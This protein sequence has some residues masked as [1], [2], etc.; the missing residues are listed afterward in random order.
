MNMLLAALLI[1][2]LSGCRR[3]VSG[4]SGLSGLSSIF[5]EPQSPPDISSFTPTTSGNGKTVVITGTN[6]TGATAVTFGGVAAAFVVDDPTQITATVSTG[7]SGSVAVTTAGG[8]ATKTGFT[9]AYVWDTVTGSDGTAMS[10]HTPEVGTAPAVTG[11]CTISSNKAICTA[12]SAGWGLVIY[13][14]GAADVFISMQVTPSNLT[15]GRQGIAIRNSAPGS[16]WRATIKSTI[17]ELIEDSVTVRAS[18]AV[19]LS[20]GITYTITVT[21]NGQTITCQLDGANEIN[22][23]SATSNQTTTKHGMDWGA[24]NLGPKDNML[25]RKVAA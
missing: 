21:A 18:A 1:L 14:A 19:S 23:G 22:Y 9:W 4:L 7:D 2:F 11:T 8:T 5:G 25:V 17:F 15:A 12:V 6:F 24:A 13:E 3:L 10:A 16:G 20:T